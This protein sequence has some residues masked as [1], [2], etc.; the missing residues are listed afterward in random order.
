M[1]ITKKLKVYLALEK[2]GAKQSDFKM[3]EIWFC[4][5]KKEQD[6]LHQREI[7]KMKKERP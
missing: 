5:S 7:A 4:L 6:Y 2:K 3:D 1:K